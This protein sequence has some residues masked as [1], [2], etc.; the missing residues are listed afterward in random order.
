MSALPEVI[1]LCGFSGSGKT[2]TGRQLSEKLGYGFTDTDATVEE[3]L[4]KTIP[5]IFLKHGEGKF[6]FAESDVLRMAIK[7]KPQ[8]IALGGGTISDEHT[9]AY[10]R[11]NGFLIY[12]RVTPETV[13]ERIQ[14]SHL[15]P[16]LQ[17]FSEK[18]ADQ[19]EIVMAR[20]RKLLDDREKYYMKSDLVIDTE[21]KSVDE[22]AAE[23]EAT[24]KGDE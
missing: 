13:Y 2:E 1:L 10:I 15:R 5:E 21:G 3:S 9:L 7:H 19:E 12:L 11:E 23:I 16:M 6:R 17:Q 20:I 18:E 22:V 14:K 4:G 8:V 24:L